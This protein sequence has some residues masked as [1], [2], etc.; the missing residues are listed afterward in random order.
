[1]IF[2][3]FMDRGDSLL[4]EEYAYPVI[5]GKSY[6]GRCSFAPCELAA[7]QRV[8]HCDAPCRSNGSA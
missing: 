3:V 4:L 8:M 2:A 6:S 5:T 7:H 1:M